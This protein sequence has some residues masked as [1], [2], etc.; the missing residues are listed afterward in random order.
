VATR[1]PSDGAV[2]R[3]LK[4]RDGDELRRERGGKE[5]GVGCGE[6]RHDRGAFYR[7][8]VGGRRPGDGEVKAAPLM[9][10]CAS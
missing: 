1:R 5:G 9:A 2:R 3:R 10:V 7:C 4:A 8:R 6:M